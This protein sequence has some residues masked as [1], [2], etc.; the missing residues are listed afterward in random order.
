VLLS[1]FQ[2]FNAHYYCVIGGGL[3][4]QPAKTTSAERLAHLVLVFKYPGSVTNKC[5]CT[6]IDTCRADKEKPALAISSRAV[7]HGI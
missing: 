7:T 6:N 4:L 2:D 1:H 5:T 3:V